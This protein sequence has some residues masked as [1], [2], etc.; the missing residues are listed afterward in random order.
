MPLTTHGRVQ[1]VAAG[2]LLRAKGFRASKVDV[3]F[4]SQLQRAYETCE[5]ALA[6]MAGPNQNTWSSERI[7][8]DW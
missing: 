5:L 4:T 6:S 7:R 3:A 8:R 2:Q 1:A